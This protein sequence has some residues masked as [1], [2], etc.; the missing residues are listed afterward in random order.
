LVIIAKPQSEIPEADKFLIDQFIMNGGS[1]LWLIDNVN[2]SM[3]SL[4]KTRTTLGFSYNLNLD[5]QL[6]KY[7]IRINQNL[8]QDIQCAVIPVNTALVGQEAKFAP[9]PW[10]YFP[11][12]APQ[13]NHSITR[14]LD[15]VKMQFVN[16]IDTVGE[17]ENVKKTILLSSS[18][19]GRTTNV[20][21]LVDL[22]ITNEQIE[23]RNFNKSN[24]TAAVL[25][26]GTFMSVFT[27]RTTPI[28]T[29]K[30]KFGITEKSRPTKMIVISDGDIIR[31]QVRGVGKNME[32]L[33]LGYDRVTQQTFGN[34]EFILNCVNYL[35][36][37]N[38]LLEARSKDYK[39]R[40]LDKAKINQQR[41]KWQFINVVVPIILIILSG[42]FFSYRRKKKYSK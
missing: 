28:T 8:I 16:A 5:D 15:M 33:P 41:L 38:D 35:C 17:Y 23:P 11:L 42:L 4:S 1:T 30:S 37:M 2:V 18:K 10:I 34:K 21:I 25:L 9:A 13:Q 27:N 22:A 32:I 26:E 24:L 3:D 20:P 7:G 31:N 12:M 39:L 29:I 14:N 19:Y 40:L 36:N 6:F